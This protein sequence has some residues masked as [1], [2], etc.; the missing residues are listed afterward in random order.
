M[1]QPEFEAIS[2]EELEILQL[3]RLQSTINRAYR[4]V[5]FYRR[6]FEAA[7]LTPGDIQDLK[8]LARVPFTTREDLSENYP[9]GLFA[10]PLKDIVRIVSSPGTTDRPL[11]VGY[12]SQDVRL[13]LELLAR[14]Y[15]AAG[16]TREDIVQFILPPGLANWRR[17][18]QAGAEYLGASVIPAATLNFAKELMVMRDYKTSVL[19]STPSMAHHLLTVMNGLRVAPAELSLKRALLVAAPLTLKVREDLEQTLNLKISRAYGITEVMGPGL[20]FSCEENGGFHFNAD[21]FYPEVVDPHTGIPL[22][23]G[24]EGE[25]VITTLSTMAFPLLRFRSGD[26]TALTLE[27]CSCGRT[28][29]RLSGIRG[30]VDAICSVG[31]IK[32]HPDQLRACLTASLGGHTPEYRYQVVTEDGLEVLDLEV[33]VDEALFS[34][35]IKALEGLCR[36]VRRYFQDHLGINARLTLKETGGMEPK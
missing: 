12:T 31:G 8:D 4:Q 29:P 6:R 21:H 19:V 27:P 26:K 13:W 34:D 20:A 23:P 33:T 14:L 5:K 35:E 22:P 18:L 25:L 15:T 30:R 3:E 24:E 32:L 1:R 17:D 7:G 9:Y 10:V 36:K 11:V 2:P 16:V 28:L